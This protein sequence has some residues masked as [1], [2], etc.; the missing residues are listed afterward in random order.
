M[1]SVTSERVVEAL[2]AWS[3]RLVQFN[4]L[5]A[6]RMGVTATELQCL[7]ELARHGP[8]TPGALARRVNLSTGA[9][10]RMVER[11][12]AAGHVRRV[13]DP[14]DRRRVLVEPDPAALARIGA[15]YDPLNARL[16]ADLDGADPAALAQMASFL[17][18]AERTTEDEITRL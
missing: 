13:P 1:E 3:V 9:A 8:S 12:D 17:A 7:Y 18:A 11:L 15:I 4:G 2:A 14:D 16:A 5:V 10:S 6:D